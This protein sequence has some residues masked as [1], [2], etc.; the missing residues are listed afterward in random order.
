MKR[1]FYTIVVV[2]L[3][4]IGAPTSAE[5]IAWEKLIDQQAQIYEDPYLDLDYDQLDDLRTVAMETAR[6]ESGQLSE[7]RLAASTAKLEQASARLADAGIDADWLIDQ[8]WVVAERRE[9]SGN[10]REHRGRRYDRFAWRFCHTCASS[11]GRN[12]GCLPGSR[13]RHVQPYAAAKS[14]PDDPSTAEWR[15][16]TEHDA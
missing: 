4:L 6:I 5:L 7:E 3:S 13:T 11:S 2:S 15:L 9:K 14:Q 12:T 16:V 1:F 10:R 8:R